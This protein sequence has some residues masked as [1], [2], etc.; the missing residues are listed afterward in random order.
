MSAFHRRRARGRGSELVEFAVAL[1]ALVLLALV[2]TE[3]AGMIGAHQVLINAAREGA[4]LA[5]VPGELNATGDINNRVIAYAAANGLTLTGANISINQNDVLHPGGGACS[6]ANPCLTASAVTVSYTYPFTYLPR[7]PFGIP[8]TV[9]LGAT[10][11]MRNF[12]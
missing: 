12:Y 5:V 3:A 11:V 8:S 10:V 4:R 1:P 2:V 9:A 6:A 7:M